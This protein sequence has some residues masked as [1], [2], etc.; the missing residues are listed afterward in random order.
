MPYLILNPSRNSIFD[1]DMPLTIVGVML[2]Q[3]PVSL[4]LM[5]FRRRSFGM[6][7]VRVVRDESERD[8]LDNLA[9]LRPCFMVDLCSASENMVW[10]RRDVVR[11]DVHSVEVA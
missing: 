5:T 1:R 11:R 4:F 10:P 3:T 6:S 9:A 7:V 8:R 2:S